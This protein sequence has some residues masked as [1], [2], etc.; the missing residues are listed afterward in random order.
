MELEIT[1]FEPRRKQWPEDAIW[2]AENP[3]LNSWQGGVIG[4][5]HLPTATDLGQASRER[6]GDLRLE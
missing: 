4:V 1:D 3:M 2:Q 6:P 5:K